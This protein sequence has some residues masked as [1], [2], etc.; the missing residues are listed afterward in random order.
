VAREFNRIVRSDQPT[1]DDFKSARDLGKPPVIKYLREWAESISVHAD[2]E[3][4]KALARNNRLML[5]RHV[6]TLLAP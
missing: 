4:S 5:G 6:V 3:H 1:L 2:L